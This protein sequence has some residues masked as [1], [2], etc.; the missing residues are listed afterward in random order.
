M[1]QIRNKFLVILLL[2]TSCSSFVS[3]YEI[4]I[5]ETL[6]VN[7]LIRDDNKDVVIDPKR[8]LMWQDNHESKTVQKNWQDAIHYCENLTFAG[9]SDWRLPG[10]VELESIA[11]D[12]KYNPAIK[13]G[14]KNVT[15][16]YYWSSSPNVSDSSNAWLVYF[17]FGNDSWGGKSTSYLVRCVRDSK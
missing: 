7:T 10:I 6:A 14:F 3:G 8:N 2:I 15:S 16:D 17:N 13:I 11:D 9:Y 12:T 1:I 5:N 4:V